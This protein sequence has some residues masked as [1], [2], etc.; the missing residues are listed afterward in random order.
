VDNEEEATVNT[1]TLALVRTICLSAIVVAL[2]VLLFVLNWHAV[3]S[4]L[5]FGVAALGCAMVVVTAA[6]ITLTG[7][8]SESAV[9]E[10]TCNAT[11][12]ESAG[13]MR[14]RGR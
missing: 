1:Q 12:A 9:D 3:F 13:S 5:G 6:V 2:L 7:S 8:A 10:A 14:T 11:S 4:R